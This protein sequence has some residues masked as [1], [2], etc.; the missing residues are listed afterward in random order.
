MEHH[1]LDPYPIPRDKAPLYINEPWL[2]DDSIMEIRLDASEPEQQDDNVR[3][4]I[5]LDINKKAVLRRLQM[6]IARYGEANEKNE[7]D[8]RMDVEALIS[9]VEIYDQ[10]WYVRHMPPE[11]K[12]SNE[13]IGLVKEIIALL[14]EIPD[15]CAETFSFQIIEGLMGEYL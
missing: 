3:I 2:I 1:R 12:H 10:I 4:Y 14:E 6:T 8:F 15:G 9:Q 5:P 7:C 11:T 13:A